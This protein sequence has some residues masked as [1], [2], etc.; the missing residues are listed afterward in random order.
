[1]VKMKKT[2]LSIC[3]PTYNR[4]KFLERL[5]KNV[6]KETNKVKDKVELCISDNGSTDETEKLVKYYKK[7]NSF[8]RYRKNRYNVG[9]QKNLLAVLKMARGEYCWMMGDDDLFLKNSISNIIRIINKNKYAYILS[10][11]LSCEGKRKRTINW[12]R[13]SE[14]KL[15]KDKY[16]LINFIG[17]LGQMGAHIVKKEELKKAIKKTQG[18]KG[19]FP[20][21]VMFFYILQKNNFIYITKKTAIKG[22][23]SLGTEQTKDYI[24]L[25]Y[26]NYSRTVKFL[27]DKKIISN[28]QYKN[29]LKIIYK[30]FSVNI[31]FSFCA[32]KKEDENAYLV[33]NSIYNEFIKND[34]ELNTFFNAASIFLVKNKI[35]QV[36]IRPFVN[37]IYLLVYIKLLN[38]FRK[39]KKRSAWEKWDYRRKSGAVKIKY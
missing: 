2:L 5:I 17:P 14:V 11:T 12:N 37:T 7:K 27:K 18:Y 9:F 21:I 23:E 36:L 22:G 39:E 24:P 20:Q 15:I 30:N 26:L 3:V 38:L 1:M 8:I 31:L 10:D 4:Q 32:I 16:E 35:T 6:I 25:S 33:L 19:W 13:S 28:D 34:K 29:A